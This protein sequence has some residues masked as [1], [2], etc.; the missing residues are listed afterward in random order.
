[1]NFDGP[2]RGRK[3]R[4]IGIGVLMVHFSFTST[5][6]VVCFGQRKMPGARSTYS[7]DPPASQRN[8]DVSVKKR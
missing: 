7:A 6:A 3:G 5:G 8:G 2:E 4:M 1:M